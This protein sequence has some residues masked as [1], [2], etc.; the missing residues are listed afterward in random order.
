[1]R[2]VDQIRFVIRHFMESILLYGDAAS[3]TVA[4]LLLNILMEMEHLIFRFIIK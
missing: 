1:M 2:E 3:A 4:K